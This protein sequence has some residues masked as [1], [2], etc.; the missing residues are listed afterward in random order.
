MRCPYCQ[1]EDTQ[2]KDS[3]PAE[4]GAVIRRRRVCSVCGGRFTTFERV[5]LRDLMVVKK[6]GRRVPFDRDKLTRS[7]E[8]ALRKRDVDNDRVER[9]I[10]GI[11]RQLESSGEA[12]V[13][14]DEIGRLAMDALKGIDDIAYIRFA[15]VYRNFSKAVDFHNVIDELTVA[16]TEDD[17]DA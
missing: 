10:S 7:I 3:R 16:E 1:S 4:D 15:S 8:V 12:E 9:A 5:Q 13:T 11:V 14:S 6:S 17:L 2:V